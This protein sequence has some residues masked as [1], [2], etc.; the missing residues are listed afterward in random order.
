VFPP[1]KIAVFK[2]G[3]NTGIWNISI[4]KV[5][6]CFIQA[7]DPTNLN[8]SSPIY[9]FSLPTNQPAGLW[10]NAH[11]GSEGGGISRTVSRQFLALEGYTGN[12][13]SPSAAKPSTDPTVNRGIVRL[14]A[15]GNEVPI[16]QDLAN[17]F[18]LPPGVT[19]N[20]PTGIASTDGTNF[21]GTG[22]V[23]GTSE[24]A[25]GTLFFSTEEGPPPQELQNYIQAAAE[26]R[27][28]GSVLY[29]VVPGQGVYNFLDPLNNDAVV[30]LPFDPDV[31]NPVEHV[32]LT[33]LFIN[34]GATFQNI[35]NFDMNPQGTIAYGADE[36]L[37]IVKFTNSGGVWSQAPYFFNT[38]NLGTSAQKAGQGG[39]FGICVDFSGANPVIYATTMETGTSP[40]NNKQGNPNQNRLI[41]IVDTGV[42]P[43]NSV[44]AQTLATAQT[45]NE[46]FRGIDF[47]PDLRP[48]I[49]SQ[50]ANFATT[51]G[52]AAT[53]NVGADA[54]Y[55]LS[56]QWESNGVVIG[57]TATNATLNLSS[58]DTTFNGYTY[59]CIV[60]DNFGAVTSTP[61]ILT[62]TASPVA[63]VIT[64][65]TAN[66]AAFVGGSTTF[67]PINP[68]G[69]Q[70]FGFQWYHGATQLVDDGA[71]YFGSTSNSLTV[72]NLTNTD[73]GNYYLV[74]ANGAGNASNLVDVLTVN[75]HKATITAGDPPALTTTFVGLNVSI[76]GT[77]S[78][79]SLPLTNQW[80][81]GTASNNVTTALQ[82]GG[83]V[84][85]SQSDTL[86]F[87]SSVLTNNGFYKEIISNPAGSVTSTVAQLQVLVPPPLSSVSY[88]N[89]VYVQ[90]FDS[91]PD[92]GSN[93]INSIN[94]PKDFGS[95]NNVF[96]SLA[97]PFDFAYP[98]VNNNFVGG[99]GL[100]NSMPGWYGAA[101]TLFP[102]VDGITRF[103]AQAGDQ[104]TGGV[105]DFGPDDA[106]GL[107]GTNRAL[108]L[109]S[110]GTTGSTTFA[111]KL[112]NT[113]GAALNYA[114]LNFIGE[115]WH[116]GTGQRTMSVG[117]TVDNTANS[118]T[119]SAQSIS[120]STLIPGVAFSF[121][122]NPVVIQ[123]DGTQ[124][125]NQVAEGETN[126]ALSTAWN[127][128]G[129][130][131]LIWSIEFYG[132]G[133]GNGY[134]IDNLNFYAS[135]S[136]VAQPVSQFAVNNVSY[137]PGSGP[138]PS[139]VTLG[140]T[141]VPS[142]FSTVLYA[143]NLTPPINWQPLG[144][145]TEVSH[146][147]FSSYSF[148][149]KTATNGTR[150][151]K[152]ASP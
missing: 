140:F 123:T 79:G 6:P 32:V 149:D 100:S 21:W 124:P 135:A 119:L 121:P 125:M 146:G 105:I 127:P 142:V 150:F 111:L 28:I 22:N 83:T 97:N 52:G 25:A 138:T 49:D 152:I 14:D 103:G 9:S 72:A 133:S 24:E 82:D 137:T 117:Y 55:P 141:N 58:L 85:G 84:S 13:L 27:I 73:S 112:I 115:L 147:S 95:I 1:G 30:P 114:S 110:T 51:N 87:T 129:A 99:L 18:G 70:P 12:I 34:W 20:N 126:I 17:W 78:G 134:A 61:A 7:F 94:N 47:T 39:C 98:V 148:T 57:G 132:S 108:G 71:K 81:F 109:L 67:S 113:S 69:T 36:T 66:V 3:D 93:S 122:T 65:A 102:G 88:S 80:Y 11:A 46:N 118:F 91:L 68:T 92:P 2:A 44:V 131:W 10:I 8:Q 35:A 64:N 90:T 104:T 48:Q 96:Y 63:P 38:T 40:I 59:Q 16:Y 107:K 144:Q 50:P 4:S 45:T 101:D 106:P 74:A 42:S 53:F 151:Y 56:Y 15:F 76:V 86:T 130:L 89:Q 26:A 43:G 145:P 19:Q 120:N 5:Q 136:P 75:F 77:Q 54:V 128:G 139:S 143:T 37:G 23:A 41:R 33:N 29:V 60:S 31:P 62:V 116:N